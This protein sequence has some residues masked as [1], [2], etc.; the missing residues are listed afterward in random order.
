VTGY[1]IPDY[2]R[3]QAGLAP[4]IDGPTINTD[5]CARRCSVTSPSWPRAAD[6]VRQARPC[7]KTSRP[8]TPLRPSPEGPVSTYQTTATHH[9]RPGHFCTTATLAAIT[10]RTTNGSKVPGEISPPA[11]TAL[12]HFAARY[13]S[14]SAQCR[15]QCDFARMAGVVHLFGLCDELVGVELVHFAAVRAGHDRAQ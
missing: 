6:R 11:V 10:A 14:S 15:I 9:G 7:G 1:A 5:R 8:R 4:T 13:P 2:G 3:G 12:T